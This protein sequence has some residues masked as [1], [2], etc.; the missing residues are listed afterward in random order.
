MH[1]FVASD[2]EMKMLEAMPEGIY[3]G[4]VQ[5]CVEAWLEKNKESVLA[6]VSLEVVIDRAMTAAADALKE[7]VLRVSSAKI[8]NDK[9]VGMGSL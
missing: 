3:F 5:K 1:M 6:G 8:S 9:L 2:T 4:I 7:E